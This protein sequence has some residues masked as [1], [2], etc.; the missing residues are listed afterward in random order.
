M[1]P[2]IGY[3]D[4]AKGISIMLVALFHSELK[5]Y[6]PDTVNAMG[7]F[8]MPLF[9]FL[10]GVFFSTAT[11][12]R[13]FLWKKSDALL[14][15]YFAIL[16]TALTISVVFKDGQL[17]EQLKWIFYGNSD[18][19]TWVPMW[20]LTHLFAVYC[21]TYL[22][23]RFTGIQEKNTVYKFAVVA[24]LI[25]LGSQWI[26]A[27]WSVEINL[28][29]KEITLPGLPFSLDIILISSS[30][31][32]AGAFL[33][34]AMIDFHPNGYILLVSII[35]FVAVVLLTDAHMD[36]NKRVYASPFLTTL[37]AMCGIYFVMYGSFHINKIA[38]LRNVFLAIGQ[39]SL[40][41]LIFH[42][43]IQI[44]AYNY[45]SE[46]VTPEA[47]IWVA[48]FAFLVSIATPVL[49]KTMVS[50]NKVLSVIYLPLNS[51]KLKSVLAKDAAN[52]Q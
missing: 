10:S 40:F 16:L 28:Q 27:F 38:I 44:R 23:F 8:R 6:A 36:L 47:E 17:A 51:Y 12:A 34:K 7:L 32:I 9:F 41:V 11:D 45:L 29:D 49:I 14:K 1:T 43:L 5:Y 26:D 21:F 50:K 35:V 52:K 25:T 13:T 39:S 48:L 15:P 37:G 22:I 4:I 19:T 20:F 46:L 30:F 31:F 2:R 3:I 33:R 18:T 24:I 42:F